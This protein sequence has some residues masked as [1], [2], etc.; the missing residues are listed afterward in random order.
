MHNNHDKKSVDSMEE[1]PAKNVLSETVRWCMKG[2]DPAGGGASMYA[3]TIDSALV[4]VL[5]AE[6]LVA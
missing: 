2:V 1:K 5:G 4:G 3:R 6:L